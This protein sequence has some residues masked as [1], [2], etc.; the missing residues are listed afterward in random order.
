MLPIKYKWL[1]FNISH[2]YLITFMLLDKRYTALDELREVLAFEQTVRQQCK[3]D[4]LTYLAVVRAN[5]FEAAVALR[6]K[7]DN[8]LR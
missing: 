7:L 8:S 5:L 6:A 2:L 4:N 3:V 1:M